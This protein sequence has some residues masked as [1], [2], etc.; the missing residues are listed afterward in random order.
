MEFNRPAAADRLALVGEAAGLDT[1]RMGT[2]EAAGAAID[3]VRQFVGE[4]GCP[5]RLRDVG[6]H[7][8]DF[9]ALAEAVLEEVPM[10][11]NPRSISG[12]AD[13]LELLER[14]W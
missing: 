12:I 13:I 10:L 7:E 9:S 8:R 5:M 1:R 6:V 14:A 4:L 2:E 11:E 3:A